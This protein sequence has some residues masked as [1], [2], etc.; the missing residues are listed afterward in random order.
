[1]RQPGLIALSL[2]TQLTSR[3]RK[4][5]DVTRH[6]F[7]LDANIIALTGGLI[8]TASAATASADDLT[9]TTL[10]NPAPMSFP[11]R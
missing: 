4:E 10:G 7:L 9:T 2:R 3:K 8:A 11:A 6:G 1:M 5:S